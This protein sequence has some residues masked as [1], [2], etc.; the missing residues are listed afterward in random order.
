MFGKLVLKTGAV[1]VIDQHG[2]SLVPPHKRHSELDGVS[3][4]L[5]AFETGCYTAQP[6]E[7]WRFRGP[8][9]TMVDRHLTRQSLVSIAKKSVGKQ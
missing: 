1:H 3:G 8:I 7:Y 6:D 2:T 9:A 4:P 5:R